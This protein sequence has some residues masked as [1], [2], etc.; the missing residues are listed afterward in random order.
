MSYHGRPNGLGRRGLTLRTGLLA[1]LLVTVAA[2]GCRY[3]AV[4]GYLIGGPPSIEPDFDAATGKSMTEYETT[5]AVVCYAP[6]DVKLMFSEIDEE[7][8][9]YVTYRLNKHHIKVVYPD[10]VQAWMDEH[11]DWDKPA[12]IGH[13]FDVNYVI[14]I[15]L[16]KY[17]LYEEN[18]ANLYRGRA[19][20]M[21][22]VFE[23]EDNGEG[24]KIYSEEVT[25]KYPLRAPKSTSEVTYSTFKKLYLSRLS[26]EIGRLFYEYYAGDNIP[27]AA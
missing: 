14:Y 4:L 25:S 21:V 1:L 24:T 2:S 16:H 20:A 10:M 7:L 8:G 9:K 12:E 11:P 5:V 22:S 13:A 17:N 15:D 3:V 23:M 26:E 18:S 19:E 27:D 6:K